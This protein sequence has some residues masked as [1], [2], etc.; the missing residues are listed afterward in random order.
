MKLSAINTIQ[1]IYYP[2][3]DT[4]LPEHFCSQCDE[5]E[6][7]RIRSVAFIKNTFS[8]VDPTSTAEWQAGV[9]S[10]DISIIPKVH[11][12]FDGGTPQEGAGYGDAVSTYIGSD[13]VLNF[14]DPNY[15]EN[16]AY[17]NALKRF[18]DRKIAY[19]TETKL[20][21]STKPVVVLPKAP[22]ADDINAVIDWNVQ[23]K[24]RENDT[25]CPV[26]IPEGIFD[27][28]LTE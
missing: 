28:F 8:F 5:Q 26:A 22:V 19:A 9:A 23:V 16:C 10:G 11:G 21:I 24:W 7:A 6:H 13:F 27:C 20:H 15:A 12:D 2:S 1:R 25:P 17:Y 18:R 4:P 3:C 14:F